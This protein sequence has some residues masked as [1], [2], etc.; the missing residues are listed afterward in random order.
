MFLKIGEATGK[1]L[2]IIS[3]GLHLPLLNTYVHS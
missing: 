1:G 3:I 2:S